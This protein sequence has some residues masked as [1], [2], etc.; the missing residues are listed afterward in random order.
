MLTNRFPNSIINEWNG[1]LLIDE[2]KNTVMSAMMA[3]GTKDVNN[4]FSGVIMGDIR[5]KS[6]SS[7][8]Q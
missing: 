3:A 2:E 5:G 7:L 1:N 6:D 4:R 8:R